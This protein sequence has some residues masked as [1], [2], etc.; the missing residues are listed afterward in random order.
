M[1]FSFIS[2]LALDRKD[3]L[4]T[5][6]QMSGRSI[7]ANAVAFQATDEG[8]IPFARSIILQKRDAFTF[9]NK[10]CVS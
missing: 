4:E 5:H 9:V 6:P 10:P 3:S 7:M 1:G 8:S 2:P